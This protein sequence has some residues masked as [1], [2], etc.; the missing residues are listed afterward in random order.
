VLVDSRICLPCLLDLLLISLHMLKCSW[1][2]TLH[3]IFRTVV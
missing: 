3:V 2:H 1:A